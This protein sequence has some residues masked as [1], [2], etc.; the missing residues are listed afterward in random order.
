MSEF[1]NRKI[2]LIELPRAP[3]VAHSFCWIE[4]ESGEAGSQKGKVELRRL[5]QVLIERENKA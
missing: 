2:R 5:L 1:G 3:S 4:F